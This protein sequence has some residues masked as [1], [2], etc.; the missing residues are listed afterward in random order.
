MGIDIGAAYAIGQVDP[1]WS[2]ASMVQR[3]GRS[4]RREGEPSR[5]RVYVRE[6]SPNASSELEDLLFP[7]LLRSVAMTRLMISKWLE[8]ADLDR[9][10]LS[11]LVHQIL[12]CLKQTGGM[13]AAD[14]YRMLVQRGPFRSVSSQQFGELLRGLSRKELIEQVPQGELI[15]APL[16][17]RITSSFEFYAAFQSVEEYSIRCGPDEIGKL[18][19]DQIPSVNECLILAGRRWRV[20]E[21]I[22]E[23][24]LVMV[25]QDRGG[26]APKFKSAG[27]EIHTRIMQEM[28]LVLLGQDDPSY[29][30]DDGRLMLQAAR[31]MACSLGLDKS[32][33]LI[34]PSWVQWFP[35]VGTRGLLTLWLH[36]E[37]ADMNAK[38]G[39]FSITYKVASLKEFLDH[40]RQVSEWDIAG[41]E[42]ADLLPIKS[43][44]KF[45]CFIPTELLNA[46]NARSRLD[47]DEARILAKKMAQI[48]LPVE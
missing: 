11:T 17:E 40:M 27:G 4:G 39:R 20:R 23:S 9:M 42:L 38:L 36:A 35:W 33:L 47:L 14:L 13:R 7:D 16:G 28:K 2:V 43:Y 1:P 25:I 8:S 22:P 32:D 21:I 45:D 46:A 18:P 48:I 34:Q 26:V 44:E 5:M 30:N 41:E 19:S 29:L 12:S 24:K 15:L 37:R 31:R 10:N 3:L 6:D